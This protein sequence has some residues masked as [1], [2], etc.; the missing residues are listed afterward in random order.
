[1]LSDETLR[2]IAAG[3]EPSVGR[4]MARELIAAREAIASGERW[5]RG[6]FARE[7]EDF[8]QRLSHYQQVRKAGV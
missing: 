1:M 8:G 2:E 4:Q 6:G 5:Y 7:R 3:I